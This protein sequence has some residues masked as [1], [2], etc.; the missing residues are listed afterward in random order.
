MKTFILSILLIVSFN[1]L[2]AKVEFSSLDCGVD[3]SKPNA[4]EK[5]FK[6]TLQFK[7]AISSINDSGLDKVQNA[8]IAIKYFDKGSIKTT[9]IKEIPFRQS[10]RA[11]GY[12]LAFNRKIL[13]SEYNSFMSVAPNFS[14][15]FGKKLTSFQGRLE[16]N[17]KFEGRDLMIMKTESLICTP[18]P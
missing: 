10:T 11:Y 9:N 16:I 8:D 1:S 2:A 14:G 13:G 4:S 7:K 5:I 17:A 6:I 18:I 3:H 15:V 12:E